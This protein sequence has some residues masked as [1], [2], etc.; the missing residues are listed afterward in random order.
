MALSHVMAFHPLQSFLALAV[1]L[2]IAEYHERRG[3]QPSCHDR[4]RVAW[5]TAAELGGKGDHLLFAA[6]NEGDTAELFN[7]IVD[8]LAVLA[9]QPGGVTFLGTHYEVQPAVRTGSQS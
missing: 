4:Q 9:F 5:A 3:G 7:R 8:A 6:P 2:K 1:P